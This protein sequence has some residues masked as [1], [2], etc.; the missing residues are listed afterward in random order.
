MSPG[1]PGVAEDRG[2]SEEA[3]LD[4]LVLEVQGGNAGEEGSFLRF[5]L[6]ASS[7]RFL[8]PE[9]SPAQALF[10]ERAVK[11]AARLAHMARP[12]ATEV[13]FEREWPERWREMSR[14]SDAPADELF[15]VL[16]TGLLG[17]HPLLK[18]TIAEEVNFS[19]EE[20]G[21]DRSGHGTMVALLY[22][23]AIQR[24]PRFL[25]VKVAN[26]R[27]TA[28]PRRLI[29]ALEWLAAYSR[30]RPDESIVANLSIGAYTRSWLGFE[31]KG[32][33]ALCRAAVEAAEAGIRVVA[34]AGNRPERTTCPAMAGVRRRH[35]DIYAVAQS[36]WEMSGTG[37][38]EAPADHL[39]KPLEEDGSQ[40][41]RAPLA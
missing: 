37:N 18:G 30:A 36:S 39:W 9:P 22:R 27:G 23:A 15:A 1:G 38:V 20:G 24:Q 13:A 31:C 26:A 8:A 2:V 19:D 17:D 11:E 32:R 21:E 28:A 34:A 25:N 33:C 5:V 6:D 16:D 12:G 4:E 14:R 40:T 41:P 10:R 35:P 29:R 7:G 3:W